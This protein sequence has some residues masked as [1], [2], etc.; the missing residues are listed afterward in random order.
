MCGGAG[1]WLGGMFGG[2]GM[3]GKGPGG[4]KGGIIGAAGLNGGAAVM[5]G[6]RSSGGCG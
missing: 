4:R 3:P 2:I 5:E 6:A 1:H